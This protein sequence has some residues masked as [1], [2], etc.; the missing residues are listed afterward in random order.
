M[1]VKS[2][3]AS[4]G[5]SRPGQAV[6][7]LRLSAPGRAWPTSGHAW[8]SPSA[9]GPR[10]DHVWPRL[11]KPVSTWTTSGPRLASAW[12]THALP[13]MPRDPDS[14]TVDFINCTEKKYLKPLLGLR[15]VIGYSGED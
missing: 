14:V 3:S 1:H 9:P 8:P 5:L 12:N 15:L 7:G 10:L 13:S 2:S 4:G 6:P 11:A